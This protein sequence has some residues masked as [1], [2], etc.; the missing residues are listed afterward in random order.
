MLL[1]LYTGKI[2]NN[3]QDYTIAKTNTYNLFIKLN[4][5]KKNLINFYKSVFSFISSLPDIENVKDE[6]NSLFDKVNLEKNNYGILINKKSSEAW[7]N[8]DENN[9]LKFEK[10]IIEIEEKIL[11][12]EKKIVL[13]QDDLHLYNSFLNLNFEYFILF[14]EDNFE[15][16]KENFIIFLKNNDKKIDKIIF[17]FLFFL[18]KNSSFSIIKYIIEYY[19]LTKEQITLILENTNKGNLFIILNKHIE[20]ISR[21]N[22]VYRILIKCSQEELNSIKNR[23]QYIQYIFNHIKKFEI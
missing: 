9:K 20:N 11:N 7:N 5:N 3:T 19:S 12:I 8:L 10:N 22:N 6:L 16:L 18:T 21:Y 23:N 15:E 2:K 14:F 13:L 4:E 17:I 1:E